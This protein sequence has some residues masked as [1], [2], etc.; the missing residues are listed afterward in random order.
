MFSYHVDV[1][2]G[3]KVS[4]VNARRMSSVR[5]SFNKYRY[6]TDELG[7]L[8]LQ[9]TPRSGQVLRMP[10]SVPLTLPSADS[11]NVEVNR[12]DSLLIAKMAA[13][14]LL[15]KDMMHGPATFRQRASE[16]ANILL[17]EVRQLAEGRGSTAGNAVPLTPTW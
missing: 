17:Q 10:A 5:Y 12:V 13:G 11:S 8:E 14:K 3:N 6:S 16:R 15:I 1:D 4:T 9:S 2:E 7:V